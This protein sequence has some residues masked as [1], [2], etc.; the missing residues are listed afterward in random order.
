MSYF[1]RLLAF[2]LAFLFFVCCGSSFGLENPGEGLKEV[3]LSTELGKS[4]DLDLVFTDSSGK[5]LALRDLVIKD[6][7][8][9]IV[10]AYYECPRLCGLLLSGVRDLLN[11]LKLKL[12]EDYQVLTVSFNPK[13]SSGDASKRARVYRESFT[14]KG[15]VSSGWRFLVGKEAQIKALMNQIGFNYRK[16]GKDYAHTA[17]IIVLTPK[18]NI[19]QYFT[20]INF[21]AWDLKL[22]LVEASRGY[23]GSAFDHVLLFC[24]RFDPTKGKYTWFAFNMLRAGGAF[25]LL[26]LG[27][28]MYV[29]WRKE[30]FRKDL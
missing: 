25:T 3:G 9:V 21:S 10:P 22:A 20:G 17:A 23:I 8:T 16:D 30:R 19:S 6:R 24:F 2:S 13:E 26:F 14:G 1:L 5:E 18:G 12:A 4:V 27:L 11:D 15:D 7:P 28:L 29:L